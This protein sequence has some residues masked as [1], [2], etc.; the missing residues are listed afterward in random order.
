MDA[1]HNISDKSRVDYIRRINRV[2]DYIEV[3]LDKSLSLRTL[4]DIACFSKFHFHRLFQSITGER[5]AECIQRLRLEKAGT[6]LKNNPDMSITDIALVCGFASSAS[7]ANAFKKFFG[8]SASS[9][10]SDEKPGEQQRYIILPKENLH[11]LDIA[12]ETGKGKQTYLIKG[13]DYE[14]QVDVV[15]LPQ[16]KVAYIRY[17][18]P[19]KGNTDLFSGLW[20]RLMK[21][22]LPRGVTDNPDSI[23]IAVYHDN[24]EITAEEKLRV[25]VCVSINE[26]IEPSG[27][28]GTLQLPGGKYAVCRFLLGP[29]DYSAAWGW[30]YGTWLPLSGYQP[31]DRL[32]FEW[33]P[34]RENK[35]GAGMEVDICIPVR[36]L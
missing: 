3:N 15:D 4:S 10:R 12:I 22:A 7:F 9:Y 31:D 36:P 27:E 32:A 23:Y 28:I 18:G 35:K 33:F 21:W 14:R 8:I 29:K 1:V 6:L 13:K 20:K 24:P 25:S 2:M 30:M 17:I 34:P 5:L 26:D 19:Y 11:S 16:W